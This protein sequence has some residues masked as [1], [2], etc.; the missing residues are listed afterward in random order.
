MYTSA[1]NLQFVTLVACAHALNL[2]DVSFAKTDTNSSWDWR[3]LVAQRVMRV[4]LGHP[5]MVPLEQLEIIE[6]C[7]PE[8]SRRRMATLTADEKWESIASGLSDVEKRF[9]E[10]KYPDNKAVGAMVLRCPTEELYKKVLP[11][12]PEAQRMAIEKEESYELKLR[13]LRGSLAPLPFSY[14]VDGDQDLSAAR[15]QDGIDGDRV[16]VSLAAYEDREW[17]DSLLKEAL[18]RTEE[19][20]FIM[21]HLNTDVEYSEEDLEHFR[22]YDK[23]VL[24]NPEPNRVHNLHASILYAHLNNAHA[25][26]E[27]KLGCAYVIMQ[28]SNMRWL[29]NGMEELVRERKFGGTSLAKGPCDFDGNVHPFM[30]EINAPRGLWGWGYHESSYYPHKHLLGMY[31]AMHEHVK[32]KGENI[33]SILGYRSFCEECWLQTYMLNYADLKAQEN[34][35][36]AAGI[37]V[38]G[39]GL[40]DKQLDTLL[41][42]EDTNDGALGAG[43]WSKIFAAKRMSRN[44]TDPITARIVALTA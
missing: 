33:S 4:S 40:T 30:K 13:A 21:L 24:V 41:A 9:I 6:G 32:R 34:Y 31:D 11:Y 35:Y 1:M 26:E 38:L 22:N 20:T 15:E 25:M 37:R 2:R 17:I 39:D 14:T 36:P 16:C 3:A 5:Q 10:T 12:I 23:R 18:A 43:S 42:A 29:R 7:L 27:A 28:A 44:L 19:S 8:D